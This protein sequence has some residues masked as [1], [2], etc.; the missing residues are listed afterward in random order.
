MTR[1]CF[2][3]LQYP[4]PVTCFSEKAC[5]SIVW[6]L[7]SILLPKCGIHK[8]FPRAVLYSPVLVGGLGIWNIYWLQGVLHIVDIINHQYCNSVT[9]ELIQNSF[10]Q[11]RLE[12]GSNNYFFNRSINEFTESI[13]TNSW[14]RWTWAF[15]SEFNITFRN[16]IPI[17]PPCRDKDQC[18]MDIISLQSTISKKSR[19][20]VNCC[21]KYLQVFHLSDIT[22]GD[23]RSLTRQCMNGERVLSTRNPTVDWHQQGRSLSYCWTEWRKALQKTLCTNLNYKPNT[24]YKLKSPLG[25]WLEMDSSHW[26][27]LLDRQSYNLFSHQ[28]NS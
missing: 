6:P 23:G 28:N 24:V 26:E 9:G 25:R 20:M 13:T 3:S 2:S 12:I 1:I 4:L 22:S 17:I 14:S 19:H 8:Y 18:I 7:L 11:L 15:M 21:R 10:Q 16:L 5:K 27:W